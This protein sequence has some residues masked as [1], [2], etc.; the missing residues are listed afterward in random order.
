MS[1]YLYAFVTITML[2][3]MSFGCFANEAEAR[4]A[5]SFSGS[6]I[7]DC[8]TKNH[9]VRISVETGVPQGFARWRNANP[10]F[11][12]QA[13]SFGINEVPNKKNRIDYFW[14]TTSFSAG[15]KAVTLL[16]ND[17]STVQITRFG[18]TPSWP[19]KAQKDR[20]PFFEFKIAEGR[21]YRCKAVFQPDQ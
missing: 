12:P 4:F 16:T 6:E 3:T 1:K 11:A 18:P 17:G 20:Q 15:D 5:K 21:S 13:M 8:S 9:K 7:F 19:F 10:E 14:G 2:C